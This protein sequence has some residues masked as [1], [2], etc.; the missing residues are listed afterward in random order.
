MQ[1]IS[2]RGCFMDNELPIAWLKKN[3]KFFLL[4]PEMEI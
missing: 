3:E 1:Y 2:C 4:N